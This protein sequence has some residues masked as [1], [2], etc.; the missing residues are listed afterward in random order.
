MLFK[1]L[2]QPAHPVIRTPTSLPRSL[3]QL[4]SFARILAPDYLVQNIRKKQVS[5]KLSIC[6]TSSG[7]SSYTCQYKRADDGEAQ[8][9]WFRRKLGVLSYQYISQHASILEALPRPVRCLIFGSIYVAP[10]NIQCVIPYQ[11]P[12]SKI[13]LNP[14]PH[15]K[16]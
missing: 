2:P 1:P 11:Q 8:H 3:L 12:A 13:T 15:P 9:R 4:Q 16:P 7:I 5:C 6:S 14:Q 10:N